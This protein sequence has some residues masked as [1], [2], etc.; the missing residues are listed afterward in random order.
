MKHALRFVPSPAMVV[1]CLALLVALGGVGYAA[2]ALPR[3]S[4]GTPQLK[5]NAVTSIKV[6]DRSL[7]ARDFKAGQLPR[8]ARGLTGAQGAKGDKG[9]KGDTGAAGAAGAAGPGARWAHVAPDGTIR[10]QSGGLTIQHPFPG[11]YYLDFGTSQAG[12]V[13][14]VTGSW[15]GGIDFSFVAVRCGGTAPS[16]ATCTDGVDTNHPDTIYVQPNKTDGTGAAN[17]GFY[18]AVF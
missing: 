1:S 15:L 2:T 7:L 12:K 4:V 8:G 18:I 3:N 13:I 11:E 10:E 6:K 14:S 5:K 16:E 9:D 17:A